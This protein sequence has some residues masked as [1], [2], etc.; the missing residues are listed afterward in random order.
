M[1]CLGMFRMKNFNE[2]AT[3]NELADFLKI[4]RKTLTNVLYYKHVESYY[5]SFEIPKKSGEKRIIHAPNGLLKVIQKVL[6]ARLYNYWDQVCKD[7]NIT[8]NISHAFEK[9]K[10][11]ISNS[12]IHKNKRYVINV[13]LKDFFDSFHY[14]RVKGY[15][16]KN[17]YFQLP[18]EVACVIAQLTCYNGKLP[19]GAPTSPIITNLI[20]NAMDYKILSLAK[21]YHLDYTRYADDMTFSTNDKNIV[22]NFDRF[23]LSLKSIIEKSG[24]EINDKKT[25]LIYKD[26]KQVVTGLVV[27]K[28]VNI[29]HLYY[30]KVRAMANN[31][32]RTGQYFIDDKP[33][34]MNQLEGKLSFINYVEK[35]N[36]K[37]QNEKCNN[38]THKDKQKTF[39]Y[40]NSKEKEFQKFLFYRYFYAN[41]SPIIVTEGKTDVLYLKAALKNLCIEYPDL[42]EKDVN[43]KFNFKISFFNRSKRIR[44]L[45]N[46]SQDGADAMKNLY[47]FFCD[48]ENNVYKDYFS[49]F[50]KLS[51][52]LPDNPVILIFD[53]EIKTGKRPLKKFLDSINLKGVDFKNGGYKKILPERNLF[54]VT[55]QLV[56]G[57]LECEIE[58]LFEKTVLEHEINGKRFSRDSEFDTEKYY[59]KDHFSKYVY[60]NYDKIDFSNFRPLLNNVRDAIKDYK[61]I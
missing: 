1:C 30:K 39:Y 55:H 40:L 45:F 35:Y 4:E 18:L 44:F 23:L 29:D 61:G 8:L 58:D 48:C 25:R 47:Y 22:K 49:Y 41:N 43:G 42:I 7:N 15:F 37:I 17:K 57:K 32:Y 50:K 59:S 28:K 24:F 54:L 9:K 26:S 36:N 21:H 19:Q 2:L 46:I 13:D 10:G 11:I 38:K 53:N 51:N 52:K 31:L 34:S 16:M 3:R 56:D 12:V 20:C 6:C 14:G 60:S 33:G 5:C 27:N